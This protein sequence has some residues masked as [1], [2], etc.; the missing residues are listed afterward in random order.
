[1]VIPLRQQAIAAKEHLIEVPAI[2]AIDNEPGAPACET[3]AGRLTVPAA[4]RQPQPVAAQNIS[5][6]T[7]IV[8]ATLSTTSPDSNTVTNQ[9]KK[10]AQALLSA[11]S[12]DEKH[13]LFQQLLQSG[14]LDQ[15]V[16][17]LQQEEAQN[18]NDPEIPTTIGE[19]LLN[20][21]RSIL[22]ANGNHPNDAVGIL[23][24]QADEDFDAALKIDPKH[25]EAQF[26]KASSMYY[27]PANPQTDSQVVQRLTSLIDQQDTM[28]PSPAFAQTYLMLGNEYQKIGQP[29]K[30]LATW[31]IGAQEYPSDPTLQQKIATA[32]N[33]SP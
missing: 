17:E 22:E 5:A 10:F 23:A 8:A 9:I 33:P 15:V 13:A 16:A 31:Q 29:D 7:Q 24:M 27:W 14:Q 12:R 20:K 32:G 28:S 11:K 3:A 25:W 18:S 21:V 1:M 2:A 4:I 19:A 30:A 26:V 6:P